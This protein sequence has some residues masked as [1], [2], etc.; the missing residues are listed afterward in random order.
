MTA[1]SPRARVAP[2]RAP[3]RAAVGRAPTSPSGHFVM[4]D[5]D[6]DD[7]DEDEIG[8]GK[9]QA[10]ARQEHLASS[11]VLALCADWAACCASRTHLQ[12]IRLSDRSILSL[13]DVKASCARFDDA[14]KQLLVGGSDKQVVLFESLPPEAPSKQWTHNKK[15]GCVAFSPDGR[16]VMWADAFGEVHGVTLNGED[17]EPSLILGHLSPVSHLTFTHCG[18]ALLTADREGHVR[19]S[20]WPEA[21]VIDCYYLW[22]ATPLSMVLPLKSRPLLLT[23]A[24][25]GR[26]L[27]MWRLHAGT[28]LERVPASELIASQAAGSAASGSDASSAAT[29]VA[30]SCEVAVQRLVAFGFQGRAALSFCTPECE[31]DATNAGLRVQ[32]ELECTGLAGEPVSLAYSESAA[33]LCVLLRDGTGVVLVPATAGRGFDVAASVVVHVGEPQ[34]ALA[35]QEATNDGNTRAVAGGASKKAKV[36]H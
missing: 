5:N 27:C 17:A 6:D 28:L 9:G 20:R 1:A 34:P 7:L 10:K 2:S 3:S 35:S 22:H 14:G 15:I 16:T 32:P 33:R 8:E 18:S 31:W 23:A 30:C 11:Q 29:A 36:A 25:D 19:S 12:L 13:T 24:A 26:E 4:A 21:F